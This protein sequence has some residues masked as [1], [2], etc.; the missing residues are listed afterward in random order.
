MGKSHVLCSMR[1]LKLPL[2][3]IPVFVIR[4]V[5]ITQHSYV[6]AKPSTDKKSIVAWLAISTT[7]SV[8]RRAVLPTQAEG[9]SVDGLVWS[10]IWGIM[11]MCNM[12][13]RERR[14]QVQY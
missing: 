6:Q 7:A 12:N 14:S 1:Q 13:S 4:I 2:N 3:T 5:I 8:Y 9:G 10:G 11:T